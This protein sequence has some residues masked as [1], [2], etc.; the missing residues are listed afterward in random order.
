[1]L[2]FVPFF[3]GA[4]VRWTSCMLMT[5]IFTGVYFTQ[6]YAVTVRHD[7]SENSRV[8]GIT[9]KLVVTSTIVAK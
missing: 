1:M 4:M 5:Q 3:K 2:V 9:S 7:V 6:F 8:L